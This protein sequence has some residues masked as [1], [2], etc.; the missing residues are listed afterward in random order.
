MHVTGITAFEVSDLVQK[1][2]MASLWYVKNLAVQSYFLGVEGIILS[3]FD[4]I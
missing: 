3:E 4:L 1:Y 2:E